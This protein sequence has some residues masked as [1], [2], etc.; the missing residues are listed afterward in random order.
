MFSGAGGPV[1]KPN[2]HLDLEQGVRLAP[3]QRADAYLRSPCEN[4]AARCRFGP[5][6]RR[7]VPGMNGA[8]LGATIEHLG[9]STTCRPR[10]VHDHE[11]GRL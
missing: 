5:S 9:Q 7:T 8:E 4:Q 3:L 10:G 1:C 11:E 6:Y 2:W